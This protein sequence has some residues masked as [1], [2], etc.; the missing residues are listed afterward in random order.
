M[1]LKTIGG[2]AALREHAKPSLIDLYKSTCVVTGLVASA[3][4]KPA[5]VIVDNGNG[6]VMTIEGYC[7]PRVRAGSKDKSGRK[8]ISV[9]RK[10]IQL[11][12]EMGPDLSIN[13]KRTA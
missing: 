12:V 13:Q 11:N 10:G 2:L 4:L 5:V 7:S 3:P 1:K 9:N 6:N 8:V